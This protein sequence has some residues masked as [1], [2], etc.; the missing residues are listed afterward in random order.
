[1]AATLAADATQAQALAFLSAQ[2]GTYRYSNSAKTPYNG[3]DAA[4]IYAYL[5][6]QSPGSS[7]YELAVATSDLLLSSAVGAD[8]GAGIDTGATALGDT[9]TGVQTASILPSWADGLASFLGFVTSAAG[10]VRVL[11][12]AIGGLLV[13]IGVSH[14]TG[15]SNAVSQAARK[16][17]L[18]V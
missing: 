8:I 7:P 1:V 11:K 6:K 9:L 15:A 12:V 17:P 10:W 18:P 5:A 14:M 16:V 13:V 2:Y 4:Q 3:M